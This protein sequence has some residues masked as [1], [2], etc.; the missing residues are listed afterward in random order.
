MGQISTVLWDVG[1]VL[2]TN[3][4][5]HLQRYQVLDRF[6]LPRDPFE[7]RHAE[8]NDAW[9]KDHISL[10]KYL[11]K[12]IFYE[13]RA[14][15]LD[16]FFGAM[17]EQSQL[18]PKTA[19]NLLKQIAASE[20]YTVAILNNESRALNDY[21]IDK[22]GLLEYFD[23]FVSSCYVGLRKPHIDIYKL[24]LDILQR[25]PGEVVFIDD[26]EENVAAAV[27]LGM[28]GIVHQSAERSAEEFGRLG[29]AV[30]A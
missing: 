26:R 2:L 21:R 8:V 15:T 27:S 30:T 11:N 19:I 16:D 17:K 25:Q 9:E 6:S 3:G 1:G 14:F 18:H 23:A 4:W 7:Q 28:H 13:E 24:A 29:I 5:D 20:G 22:F 10:E 12:T